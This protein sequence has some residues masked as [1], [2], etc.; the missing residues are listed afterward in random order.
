M[1]RCIIG[2]QYV[3]VNHGNKDAPYRVTKGSGMGVIC[4]GEVSDAVFYIFVE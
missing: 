2:S 3:K 4:S 1:I